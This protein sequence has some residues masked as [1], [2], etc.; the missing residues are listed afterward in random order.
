M[1]EGRCWYVRRSDWYLSGRNN[2]QSEPGRFR[3]WAKQRR[4]GVERGEGGGV[5]QAD[6]RISP[7]SGQATC[8]P[9]PSGYFLSDIK[10]TSSPI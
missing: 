2:L 8:F 3:A 10:S 7:V 4:V 1:C 5:A 9:Q 6:S